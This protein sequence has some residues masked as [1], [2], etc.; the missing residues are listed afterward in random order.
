MPI[1][2]YRCMKCKKVVNVITLRASDRGTAECPYCEGKDLKRLISRFSTIRSEEQR[3]ESLMD[4]GMLGSL[5]ENDPA[6]MA[7]WMKK[8]GREMGEEFN[9]GE[10]DQMIEES[11]HESPDGEDGGTGAVG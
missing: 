6:S 8:V 3:M 9:N 11:A 1:Y 5:D 4:P 2:E 7:R 10:I